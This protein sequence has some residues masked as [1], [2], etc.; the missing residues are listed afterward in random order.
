[1]TPF[2][3][4]LEHGIKNF[5]NIDADDLFLFLDAKCCA[6]I[7]DTA[8][9]YAEKHDIHLF[10]MDIHYT[11]YS[12]YETKVPPAVGTF[13]VSYTRNSIDYFKI[14]MSNLDKIV[15]LKK[16]MVR[17]NIDT[18]FSAMSSHENLINTI[19]FYVENLVLSHTPA[20]YTWNSGR[21]IFENE[22]FLY[23]TNFSQKVK[24]DGMLIP[25]S[26]VK[27][28]IGI[29]H[30]MGEE[31]LKK[32]YPK[33]FKEIFNFKNSLRKFNSVFKIGEL[34]TCSMFEAYVSI[35]FNCKENLIVFI[36]SNDAH[37]SPNLKNS[38]LNYMKLLGINTKLEETF[39][40]S[41]LCII[42]SGE[43]VEEMLSK[44]SR[45]VTT[46]N[47]STHKSEVMSEGWWSSQKAMKDSSVKIDGVE[48]GVNKRGLNFVVWD[49][50]QDR[51]ID[52]VCF[53]TWNNKDFDRLDE[54]I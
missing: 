27:I 40:Y 19:P 29:S 32:Y 49:K 18:V 7:M 28:D 4:S 23:W 14:I 25:D 1:M 51:V 53:D 20:V 26:N 35:L 10:Q 6:N 46:Y 41:W 36:T 34:T 8:S 30:E 37:T 47:F 22:P 17:W 50:H 2:F 31:F 33:K 3:H 43:L 24:E 11:Y 45:I 54:F 38:K 52:S 44:N 9:D 12:N 15:A 16:K 21:L 13:G 5:W 42:D 48:F 39:R